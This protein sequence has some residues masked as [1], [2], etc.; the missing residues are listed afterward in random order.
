MFSFRFCA[1]KGINQNRGMQDSIRVLGELLSSR[2]PISA[3]SC[4]ESLRR[5][6]RLDPGSESLL[7]RI[8]KVESQMNF[9][10]VEKL[11]R[12]I[13]AD[14]RVVIIDEDIIRRIEAFE[15]INWQDVQRNSVQIWGYNIDKLH[16]PEIAHH[17][18]MYKWHLEYS[19]FLGYMEGVLKM[20]AFIDAGGGVV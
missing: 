1:E 19:S 15:S 17:A 18:G 3:E 11:F 2:Q 10:E 12:I 13:S 20:N 7:A 9:P 5:E 16:I 6:L 8:S 14:T 4:T